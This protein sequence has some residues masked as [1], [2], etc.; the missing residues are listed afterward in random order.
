MEHNLLAAPLDKK[1]TVETRRLVHSTRAVTVQHGL[2]LEVVVAIMEAA[3][4]VLENRLAAVEAVAPLLQRLLQVLLDT[5][6]QTG[7][8]HHMREPITRAAS[9]ELRVDQVAQEEMAVLYWFITN[10]I[11]L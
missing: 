5:T 4:E 11:D 6:A 2:A 10:K 1:I 3:V 7:F 9:M 8:Q